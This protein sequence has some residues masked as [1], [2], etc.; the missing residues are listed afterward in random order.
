VRNRL[1]KMEEL[2]PLDLNDGRKRLA[3]II[4]LAAVEDEPRH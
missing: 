4:M 2:V 3:M 1:R